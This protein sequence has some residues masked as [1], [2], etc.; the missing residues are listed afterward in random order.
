MDEGQGGRALL[1]GVRDIGKRWGEH[2]HQQHFIRDWSRHGISSIIY[3]VAANSNNENW[4][5]GKS[6][7]GGD[8]DVVIGLPAD[9][10]KISIRISTS[11]ITE[12]ILLQSL[13][14][15]VELFD[16][17]ELLRPEVTFAKK[18]VALF[19]DY[20]VDENDP[21]KERVRKTYRNMHLNMTVSF[22]QGKFWKVATVLS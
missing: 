14:E 13:A 19:R 12:N 2:H 7:G 22:V 1:H 16:P 20:T 3:R 18:D 9:S 11:L 8:W 21:V 17:S 10:L 6:Y 15:R 5:S 4:E